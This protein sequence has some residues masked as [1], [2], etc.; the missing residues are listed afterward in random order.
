MILN[1]RTQTFIYYRPRLPVSWP[2]IISGKW[3]KINLI[4]GGTPDAKTC[5]ESQNLFQSYGLQQ[6]FS[7]K[8]VRNSHKDMQIIVQNLMQHISTLVNVI[9][10]KQNKEQL[11]L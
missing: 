8:W 4:T 2:N 7:Y 6:S 10:I 1:T 11:L 3:L 5:S 9:T